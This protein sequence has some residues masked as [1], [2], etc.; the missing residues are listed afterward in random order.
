MFELGQ[1]VSQDTAD[2]IRWYRLAAAQGNAD[3]H[4]RLVA[5]ESESR[6]RARPGA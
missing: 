1:G 6:K 3:A 5:L 2:A 4:E